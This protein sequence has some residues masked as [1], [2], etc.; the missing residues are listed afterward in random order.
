MPR[1]KRP[2]GRPRTNVPPLLVY[3]LRA[4]GL[5]FRQ[6]ARKMGFG[7]GSVRRAY[8][9]YLKGLSEPR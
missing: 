8:Q 5:S 7:Y 1:T 9:L 6:I 4:E 3:Q 2:A